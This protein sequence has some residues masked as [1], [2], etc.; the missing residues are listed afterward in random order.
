VTVDERIRDYIVDLG[1][2]TR[3]DRRV[4]VGVSPRGI[5]RLFEAARALAVLR[6][7][8]YVIPDDVK[9]VVKPVFTHRIVLTADAGVRGTDRADVI[10]AVLDTVDVPAMGGE[11][12][13]ARSQRR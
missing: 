12:S 8:D 10:A 6:G 5:Q 2:A 7:R 1:R 4:E 9:W 3:E 11:Q 13:G